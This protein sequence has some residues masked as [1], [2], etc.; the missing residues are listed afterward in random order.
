MHGGDS[1]T[2]G[3]EQVL[4][5][6]S[7]PPGTY[8]AYAIPFTLSTAATVSFAVDRDAMTFARGARTFNA[9]APSNS[10]CTAAQ[11][12]RHRHRMSC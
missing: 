5:A 12:L 7:T 6:A 8:V 11:P 1:R 4:F 10:R 3:P 9:A 2:S